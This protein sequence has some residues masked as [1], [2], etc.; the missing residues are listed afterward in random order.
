MPRN[1]L[2]SG[3]QTRLESQQGFTLAEIIIV[4][5]IIAILSTYML[6]SS[7]IASRGR[8]RDAQRKTDLKNLSLVLETYINDH[9]GYPASDNQGRIL[10]CA[11]SG[12]AVC[13]WGSSFTD[14]NGEI[15]M[16][17]LPD[18]PLGGSLTYVYRSNAAGTAWQLYTSYESL[19]NPD[20][21]RDDDGEYTLAGDGYDFVDCGNGS[22]NYG[23]S[24]GNVTPDT[25]PL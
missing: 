3:R 9:G 14:E 18:D 11:P 5:A 13:N 17:Q 19:D 23:I 22:C 20:L 7:F 2:L 12:S 21:D 16:A 8:A 15:Y 1:I 6:G 10:A 4:F 24:S 25:N